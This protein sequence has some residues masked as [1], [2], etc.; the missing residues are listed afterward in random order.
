MGLDLLA[1]YLSF[2]ESSDVFIYD[3]TSENPWLS[4]EGAVDRGAG[5][6]FLLS[7]RLSQLGGF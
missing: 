4:P 6:Y 7:I 5:S 1:S 3:V 2:Q